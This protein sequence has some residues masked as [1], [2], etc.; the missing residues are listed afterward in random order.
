M[1][2][3]TEVLTDTQ[4]LRFS[5]AVPKEERSAR[6]HAYRVLADLAGVVKSTDDDENSEIDSRVWCDG[7]TVPAY[8]SS[9]LFQQLVLLVGASVAEGYSEALVMLAC[10]PAELQGVAMLVQ[11]LLGQDAPCGE[12]ASLPNGGEVPQ[13]QPMEFTPAAAELLLA[14]LG[15]AH[16]LA[17]LRRSAHCALLSAAASLGYQLEPQSEEALESLQFARVQFP[18]MLPIQAPAAGADAVPLLQ[19]DA[20]PPAAAASRAEDVMSGAAAAPSESMSMEAPVDTAAASLLEAMASIQWCALAKSCLGHLC[21]EAAVAAE[22]AG[23]RSTDLK[24]AVR[25]LQQ[26]EHMPNIGDWGQIAAAP[27]PDGSAIVSA[28]LMCALAAVLKSMPT[29]M[30]QGLMSPASTAL[31]SSMWSYLF[32]VPMFLVVGGEPVE[33][34][35]L[36]LLLSASEMVET[37]EE[38]APER[39]RAA[40]HA[41]DKLVQELLQHAP[42]SAGQVWAEHR[43]GQTT[44]GTLLALLVACNR[45]QQ[46]RGGGALQV[47]THWRGPRL[48]KQPAVARLLQLAEAHTHAEV[49]GG[50]VDTSEL[51]EATRSAMQDALARQPGSKSSKSTHCVPGVDFKVVV[52]GSSGNGFATK[53][54]DVDMC[55]LGSMDGNPMVS[56]AWPLLHT[57]AFACTPSLFRSQPI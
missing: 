24:D 37:A 3:T 16:L 34:E 56:A 5:A 17:L 23:V 46:L 10:L 50:P 11:P 33:G 36:P 47:A 52:L 13:A 21:T 15:P 43:S 4:L 1:A 45:M 44:V 9:Q 54:S 51:V 48:S 12:L 55:L 49:I 14:Q 2:Q 18:D 26:P 22:A 6:R 27:G 57:C 31:A 20:I 35:V 7:V 38:L 19:L 32:P 42:G 28:A 40:P 39:P 8:T 25:L 29:T 30:H 53:A 41:P